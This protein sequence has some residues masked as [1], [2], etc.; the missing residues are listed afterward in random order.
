MKGLSLFDIK[1]VL[2]NEHE[3]ISFFTAVGLRYSRGRRSEFETR[4]SGTVP[5]TGIGAF[6]RLLR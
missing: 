6:A 5:F 1:C 2:L 4:F 3:S